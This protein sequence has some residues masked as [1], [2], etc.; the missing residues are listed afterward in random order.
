MFLSELKI[1]VPLPAQRIFNN[2]ILSLLSGICNRLQWLKNTTVT[3]KKT[4]RKCFLRVFAYLRR[5]RA[6]F[7]LPLLFPAAAA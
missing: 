5:E 7:R 6:R 2:L 4:R 1:Y 3:F